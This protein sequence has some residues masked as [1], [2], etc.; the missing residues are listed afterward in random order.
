MRGLLILWG[1]FFS[2]NALSE[3]FI[4]KVTAEIEQVAGNC[5]E[6]EGA[7]ADDITEL[8]KHTV[9]PS[10]HTTKC[11]HA[12]IYEHFNVMKADGTFDKQATIDAFNPLKS[13]DADIYGKVLKIID[14]CQEKPEIFEDR[15]ETASSYTVCIKKEAENV[16]FTEDSF[17]RK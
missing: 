8:I 12:C 4:E 11:V 3:E 2:A 16:G 9:P 13:E 15:C 1:I 10:S 17:M 7:N 5:A 6:K 14:V